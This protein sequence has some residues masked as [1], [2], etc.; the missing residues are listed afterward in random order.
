MPVLVQQLF[1]TA[2]ELVQGP[3]RENQATLLENGICGGLGASSS[4]PIL[5]LGA[6]INLLWQNLR[7]DEG[8]FRGLIQDNEELFDAWMDL[9]RVMRTAEIAALKFAM[10]LLEEQQLSEDDNDFAKQQEK[11]V[12]HKTATLARMIQ[13][14]CFWPWADDADFGQ[15]AERFVLGLGPER[16][17]SSAASAQAQKARAVQDHMRR[18]TQQPEDFR[19][20]DA[21]WGYA[22]EKFALRASMAFNALQRFASASLRAKLAGPL[23]VCAL[24]GGPG[25]E[26]LA[27]VVARD[28]AGGSHGRLAVYEWVDTWQPIV[29]AVANLIG[30]EIG[31]YHCDVS[32]PLGDEANTALQDAEYDLFILSHVLLECGRGGG[33]AP[34]QLLRD[35]WA[36]KAKVIHSLALGGP[37]HFGWWSSLLV[38]GQHLY[39]IMWEEWLVM[40]KPPA[41]ELAPKVLCWKIITHWNLSSE[42]SSAFELPEMPGGWTQQRKPGTDDLAVWDKVVQEDNTGLASMGKPS[43]VETQVVAGVKY[44]FGFDNGDEVTVWSQPWLHKLEVVNVHQ[45]EA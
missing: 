44:K 11:V 36:R 22:K 37:G 1:D 9:L 29:D 27:A 7:R 12:Y 18:C 8:L 10:S 31:Y 15:I 4:F 21:L 17:G 3:N 40:E 19:D 13:A 26:L 2:A 41:Q 28:I 39:L 23:R 5:S 6:D 16:D 33:R 25:A 35:L 30:E 20:L 32:K 45:Q 38:T 34:L 42:G 14:T 24:G 43:N